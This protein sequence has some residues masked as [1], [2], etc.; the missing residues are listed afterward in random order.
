[1]TTDF[2]HTTLGSTGIP[3]H[4]VGFSASYRPGT[5]TVERAIDDGLNLLFCFGLDTQLLS[6]V[7]KIPAAKRR[8]LCLVT[9]AY[10]MIWWQPN[11]RK[12]LEKRLRQ[13]GTDYID[14]FLWLGVMKPKEMPE[15]I[16]E[17]MARFREEGKVRAIGLSCHDRKFA[18]ELAA[19]NAVDVLM[20]R[21]NA[22]H[23]GAEQ[24]IF[25]HVAAHGT[26][27]ISYTSTRWTSLLRPPK[28][29]PSTRPVPDASTAYRFVLSH[30]AVHTILMAPTN[31]RQYEAN[32][33][34]IRKGPLT[35]EEMAYVR[36][37]GDAVYRS[38]KSIFSTADRRARK[39]H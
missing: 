29:W 33:N 13:L 1:M 3:V 34:G 19:R 5:R 30:P 38:S 25:P 6:V 22:A 20:I 10:N 32:I 4:R 36:E 2:L 35:D 31:E 14:V 18:G 37:F 7:R 27:V 26:G 9:G 28:G 12:S 39:A 21:Y 11:L 8:E 17:E 16:L 15:S 24:D 23:R